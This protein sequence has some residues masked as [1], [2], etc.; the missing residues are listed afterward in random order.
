M[1]S[2]GIVKDEVKLVVHEKPSFTSDSVYIICSGERVVI[3]HDES[4]DYM[5][6]VYTE[7][8][9]EG[10]CDKNFIEIEKGGSNG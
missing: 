5:Y 6:K 8:G 1:T 3:D 2:T 7:I 9:I 10:F 4:T